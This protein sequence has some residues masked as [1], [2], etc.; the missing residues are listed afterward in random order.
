MKK[1]RFFSTFTG[2][3]GLDWGLEKLNAECIGFSEIKD[4]S[5]KAYL[6]HYPDRKNFGDITKI[7][8]KDLPDFDVFTGGFPCQAFSIAGDRK[9]FKDRRGQMIFFI[10]D[11]LVEKKP[12]FVVLENV[13]GLL[14]HNGGK[15]YQNV[16][17]ILSSAGYN[18][19][20]V[21]LNASHYGS[22]QARERIVFLCRRGKEF[23]KKNPEKRNGQIRFRDVRDDD[24]KSYRYVS[25]QTVEKFLDRRRKVTWI[26]GYDKVNTLTTGASTSGR[27][28]VVT[29]TKDG[30]FRYLTEI[31]GERLQG[32]PDR[33]TECLGRGDRW[34][35]IGNAVNCRMSEYIFT[36]YLKGLWW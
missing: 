31:E 12:E 32:F 27:A 21:L 30:K 17:K 4:S 1:L 16:F 29:Q 5:I 19:R 14:N 15:T 7:N 10:Y 35:A 13:K 3:G 2:I 9:G 23:E 24:E 28:S 22:A 26:G 18:V 25:P 11:I 34:Y 33:W 8:P 20:C 6:S 36:D